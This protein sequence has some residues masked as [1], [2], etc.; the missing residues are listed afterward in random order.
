MYQP[1]GF[2]LP[3]NY[4]WV[5]ILIS[6]ICKLKGVKTFVLLDG[7]YLFSSKI[8]FPKDE[9][10]LKNIFDY[11]FSYGQFFKKVL[12]QNGVSKKNI[13]NI[14]PPFLKIN[15]LK[16]YKKYDACI[17][18]YDPYIFN[19]NTTWD[20]QILI[21]LSILKVLQK[22]DYKNIVLKIKKSS[23]KKANSQEK[24]VEL[25]KKMFKK[26]YNKDLSLNLEIETGDFEK[27]LKKSS[28]VIGGLS[29]SYIE[30]SFYNVPYY[31]FEPFEN[32]IYGLNTIVSN[33]YINRKEI[34]LE[35]NILKKNWKKIKLE[36]LNF[37]KNLSDINFK[38]YI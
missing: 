4:D 6:E 30:S 15:S 36:N 14:K 38:K 28:L 34:N 11:H 29:T 32:G 24:S 37:S 8:D 23:Q 17:L 26:I 5:S 31:I 1:K 9:N 20:K 10:N 27:V 35:K 3:S 19:L 2:I 21:E 33:S 12:R 18:A 16:S 22:I 13:I 25:Y 7:F